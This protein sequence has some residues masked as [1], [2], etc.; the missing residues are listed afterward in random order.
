MAKYVQYTPEVFAT[1][2]GGVHV[3]WFPS[4]FSQ[5]QLGDR[6]IGELIVIF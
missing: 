3:W 1:Q 2:D 4:E 5:S 6:V